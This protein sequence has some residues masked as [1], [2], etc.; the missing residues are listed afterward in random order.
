MTG[1]IVFSFLLSV[2]LYCTALRRE[3]SKLALGGQ[4]G[5][6]LYD[7]FIGRELNPRI[8]SFDLKQFCELRPGLIGWVALNLGMAAKQYQ[9]TGA[10]SGSMVLVNVLQALYVW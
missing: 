8:G 1:S 3:R 7:F 5:N 10:V 9:N 4:S 6:F 2:Y